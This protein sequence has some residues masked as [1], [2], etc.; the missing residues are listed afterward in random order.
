MKNITKFLLLSSMIFTLVNNC[1]S[2]ETKNNIISN[3]NIN[4]YQHSPTHIT[5]AIEKQSIDDILLTDN[6]Y[7]IIDNV[8][9]QTN[10]PSKFVNTYTKTDYILKK[11]Q[12]KCNITEQNMERYSN[13]LFEIRKNEI[14]LS[15]FVANYNNYNYN[16]PLS[17]VVTS[18]IE[19]FQL[20]YNNM[21]NHLSIIVLPS[22]NKLNKSIIN[23]IENTSIEDVLNCYEKQY[24]EYYKFI[25]VIFENH[26]L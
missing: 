18:L 23:K 21:L 7:K 10:T 20:W 15:T 5:I 26:N 13:M 22:N 3:D 4:N 17:N 16:K 19:N 1:F 25:K 9:K 8:L 24:K 11:I 12:K 2:A 14:I 6:E